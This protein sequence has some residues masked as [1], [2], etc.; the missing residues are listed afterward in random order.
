MFFEV[1]EIE[2]KEP[3]QLTINSIAN[4]HSACNEP[5]RF[6]YPEQILEF[7]LF[8]LLVNAKQN[9]WISMDG[10]FVN[11]LDI[12]VKLNG[13]SM[14]ITLK[15][16]GPAVS[17]HTL[18][19]LNSLNR[20]KL[21]WEES[22]IYLIKLM[23]QYYNIGKIHFFSEKINADLEWFIVELTLPSWHE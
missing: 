21:K 11:K 12:A 7:I 22:G 4:E 9:R 13:D 6:N 18:A 14:K 5:F 8:E 3:V 2:N 1:N 20:T 17:D 16:T 23:L 19:N 15:N 10:E